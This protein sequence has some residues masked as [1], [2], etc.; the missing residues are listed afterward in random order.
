MGKM[1]VLRVCV[2]EGGVSGGGGEGGSRFVKVD[3]DGCVAPGAA[4]LRVP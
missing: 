4:L 2:F 1:D 3:D